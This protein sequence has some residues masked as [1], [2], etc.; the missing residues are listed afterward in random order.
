[1]RPPIPAGEVVVRFGA[2]GSVALTR[3]ECWTLYVLLGGTAPFVR[4]Q[5]SVARNGGRRDVAL[6]DD[7]ERRDVLEALAGQLSPGLD[8]LQRALLS[9]A[10]AATAD[11]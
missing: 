10:A 8:E 2:A 5:L 4:N 1:M 11:A 6:T 3:S 9:H 7:L